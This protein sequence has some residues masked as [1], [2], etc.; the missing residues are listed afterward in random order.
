MKFTEKAKQYIEHVLKGELPA[1]EQIRLACRRTAN[2][3][4]RQTDPAFPYY[5]DEA[6]AERVCK[7]IQRF[8]HVKG[9]WAAQSKNIILE[10]WQCW[11]VTSLYGWKRKADGKRKYRRGTLVIPRKQGKSLLAAALVIIHLLFDGEHGAECYCG[12]SNQNQAKEIF[13]AAQQM[14]MQDP[15]LREFFGCEVH[16][17]SITVAETNSKALPVIGRPKDGSNVSFAVLDETHQYKD[18]SL[19]ES[20][21]T[22]TGA[23]EQPMVISV[24]TA[25]FG[26]ENP[27]RQL[28]LEAE[29][30]LQG[31]ADD[32]ELFIAIYTI[33]QGIDWKSD[34]ALRM[35]NPNA[36]VSVTMDFL[37]AQQLQA[38]NNQE[39]YASFA[40]KHL[41]ITV[42]AKNA[43]YSLEKWRACTDAISP[44]QFDGQECWLGV[45]LSSKLDLTA[46]ATVFRRTVDNHTHFYGF[47]DC[48]VPEDAVT[49]NP[50]YEQ[51]HGR[52]LLHVTEGNTI[53][54]E[55]IEALI[56]GYAERFKI[57]GVSNLSNQVVQGNELDWWGSGVHN[58]GGPGAGYNG[59]GVFYLFNDENP[60]S[61]YQYYGGTLGM[62]GGLTFL[63]P[64]DWGMSLANA[65]AFGGYLMTAGCPAQVGSLGGCSDP[66]Y[67][68]Y[69]YAL[70]GGGD[71][72]YYPGQ[73]LTYQIGNWVFN[74]RPSVG[75]PGSNNYPLAKWNLNS[76]WVA[77][78]VVETD[79][80]GNLNQQQVKYSFSW[81]PGAA[82]VSQCTEQTVS[83]SGLATTQEVH[84]SPP[85]SLGAH[86]WIGSTRVSASNQL[87]V[88]FCAD[89]TGG[90]PPSGTWLAAAF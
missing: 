82:T 8:R 72:E 22:G 50:T 59:G 89:A 28:Q 20:F 85:A 43:F 77:G 18:L 87:A 27:C 52:G 83:V 74:Q 62:P 67:F 5:Y 75:Y 49:N 68:Y 19:L 17:S 36:G 6:D 44:A 3:L 25:G 70:G 57:R 24:S 37:R 61:M 29:K 65:P 79:A 35:A 41:D 55:D 54:Y 9:R 15:E 90:T 12:A 31:T 7:I 10:P 51:W 34:I 46:I 23:R 86:I 56:L 88:S 81:T 16:A 58:V 48:F 14:L 63:G 66:N 33:D 4:E 1:C 11:I 13:S 42:A 45:D 69:I 71:L 78:D 2:H 73:N 64:L 47:V 60:H 84:V 32:E 40:T 76:G 26:T 39:K 80:S 38:V 53:S 21:Q 30:V